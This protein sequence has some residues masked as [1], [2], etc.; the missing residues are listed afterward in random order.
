[1]KTRIALLSLLTML[2]VALVALPAMA[3]SQLLFQSGTGPEG[4]SPVGFRI[5]PTAI[6]GDQI[7]GVSWNCPFH[8]CDV[9]GMTIW[10]FIDSPAGVVPSPTSVQALLSTTPFDFRGGTGFTIPGSSIFEIGPCLPQQGGAC[11]QLLSLNFGT[12]YDVPGGTNWISLYAAAGQHPDTYWSNANVTPTG[13]TTLSYD[14]TS[15][16]ISGYPSS[17][18][19][20]VYGTPTVPEP[21]S[22]VLL[23]TG[24]LG[25]AG[26]LRRKLKL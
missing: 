23:G 15:G 20:S 4:P 19:F 16:T 10:A 2:C 24:I 1:M 18:V 13:S 21:G 22:I 6:M 5:G 14:L 8:D 9:T 26:V 3:G 17:L 11:Q 25:F 12:S 7:P